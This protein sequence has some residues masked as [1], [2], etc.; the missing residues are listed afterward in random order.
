MAAKTAKKTKS[1]AAMAPLPPSVLGWLTKAQVCQA[2]MCSTKYLEQL[3]ASGRFPR[4]DK[5]LGRNPRW[6][7]TLVNEW[8][9]SSTIAP[10]APEE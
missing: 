4:A 9:Q 7:V 2:L 5:S 1:P 6:T 3:I 8:C 10:D